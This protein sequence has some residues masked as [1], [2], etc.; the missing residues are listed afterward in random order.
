MPSTPTCTLSR[1]MQ[2][3]AGNV[4][5]L[6]LERVL[7]A[8]RRRRTAR[9]GE[10]RR[11]ACR[12]SARAARRRRRSAAARRPPSCRERTATSSATRTKTMSAPSMSTSLRTD[13]EHES[14]D[15]DD[16][17]ALTGGE[18]HRRHVADVPGGAAQLGASVAAR[19]DVART[20]SPPRRRGCRRHPARSR[21]RSRP[22]S[23]CRN[24]R[25]ATRATT[26]KSSHCSHVARDEA[27]EGQ[28]PDHERGDAEEDDEEAARR[29]Q[30]D[31]GQHQ[32][33]RHPDPPG[34][35]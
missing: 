31:R 29:G 5:R 24:S 21:M 14:L 16:A 23:G 10:S 7:V 1:V 30:L 15:R 2:T 20:A 19:R 22:S 28:R 11:S 26:G 18:R 32:A 25:S 8:D 13:V 12:D 34:H 27:G 4:D 9:G 35:A 33:E 3:C 6:L 17:A